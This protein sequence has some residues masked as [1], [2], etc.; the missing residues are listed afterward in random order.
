MKSHSKRNILFI[1]IGCAN[2]QFVHPRRESLQGMPLL[3]ATAL[4]SDYRLALGPFVLAILYLSLQSLTR[5]RF[6][7]SVNGPLWL[8]QLW[9]FAYF[10][11]LSS[12]P[13]N[14]QTRVSSCN[15]QYCLKAQYPETSSPTFYQCID[16]ILDTQRVR[17]DIHFLPFRDLKFGSAEYLAWQPNPSQ[18]VFQ[19]L[20][21]WASCVLSRD[22]PVFHKSDNVKAYCPNMCTLDSLGLSNVFLPLSLP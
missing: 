17:S 14:Y 2:S 19:A 18:L 8:L 21:T 1:F 20:R 16:V 12:V 9:I 3:L 7:G 15:A 22:L 13:L 10:L 6:F 5:E 4:A 11:A